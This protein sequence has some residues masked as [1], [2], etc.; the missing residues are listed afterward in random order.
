MFF[1]FF[2]RKVTASNGTSAQKEG[3]IEPLFYLRDVVLKMFADTDLER[4]AGVGVHRVGGI[5]VT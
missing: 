3:S 1:R 4:V 2:C 5:I